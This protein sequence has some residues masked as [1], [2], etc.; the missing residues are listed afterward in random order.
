MLRQMLA[1]LNELDQVALFSI[2]EVV[3]F[4]RRAGH[5][6]ASANQFSTTS[7]GTRSKWR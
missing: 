1:L 3:G 5:S 2:R 7:P 4:F 6:Q